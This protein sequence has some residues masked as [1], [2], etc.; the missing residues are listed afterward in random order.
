MKNFK[1]FMVDILAYRQSMQKE[2]ILSYADILKGGKQRLFDKSGEGEAKAGR[3][4]P[5]FLEL[6]IKDNVS[7]IGNTNLTVGAGVVG[8][9]ELIDGFPGN[10]KEIDALLNSAT[11]D[12]TKD[13]TWNEFWDSYY[14]GDLKKEVRIGSG[15][16]VTVKENKKETQELVL[17][18]YKFRLITT[19]TAN[20]VAPLKQQQAELQK[21][22][23][24]LQ[25]KVKKIEGRSFLLPWE[26]QDK[27]DKEVEN[28]K[29]QIKKFEGE[30]GAINKKITELNKKSND[31]QKDI[32]KKTKEVVPETEDIRTLKTMSSTIAKRVGEYEAIMFESA[33]KDPLGASAAKEQHKI[34]RALRTELTELSQ[35]NNL[36]YEEFRERLINKTSGLSDEMQT[37]ISA[38]VAQLNSTPLISAAPPIAKPVADMAPPPP[39]PPAPKEIA[40]EAKEPLPTPP[41]AVATASATPSVPPIKTPS[42]T[43]IADKFSALSSTLKGNQANGDAGVKAPVVNQAPIQ[44]VATPSDTRPPAPKPVEAKPQAKPEAKE[45]T[46]KDIYKDAFLYKTLRD[47]SIASH[48]QDNI[49]FL[50]AVEEL[51]KLGKSVGE[52]NAEFQNMAKNLYDQFLPQDAPQQVNIS[53]NQRQLIEAENNK[54]PPVFSMATFAVAQGEIEKMTTDDSF[55]RF[56]N[57]EELQQY[58]KITAQQG[59]TVKGLQDGITKYLSAHPDRVDGVIKPDQFIRNNALGELQRSLGKAKEL[60]GDDPIKYNALAQEV[61]AKA[62]KS[63]GGGNSE[64]A[65]TLDETQKLLVK[66]ESS[67]R[68]PAVAPTA[69]KV[70]TVP[71]SDLNSEVDSRAR[72]RGQIR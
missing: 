60:A 6:T 1:T 55:S 23:K 3:N 58:K 21:E 27:L 5:D 16:L 36:T 42:S 51:R 31:I 41:N 69:L 20:R 8:R 2:G 33:R 15:E 32:N 67:M 14:A 30:I 39:P 40:P 25:D 29:A 22:I 28:A 11:T 50:I 44:A 43:S 66:S 47:F 68:A 19:L 52:G 18:D 65:K 48:T 26:S 63:F 70:E 4:K 56:L 45:V 64:I 12:L 53:A 7:K 9:T 71:E 49:S 54:N 46:L 72:T 61:V 17:T 59:E 13:P 62:I 57:S 38:E 35:N 34:A 10:A 37:H 24:A